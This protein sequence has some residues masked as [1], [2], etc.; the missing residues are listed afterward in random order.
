MIGKQE[1]RNLIAWGRQS[2]I[3]AFLRL[4]KLEVNFFQ[5]AAVRPYDHTSLVPLHFGQTFVGPSNIGNGA[6]SGSAGELTE[7]ER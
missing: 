3:C 1:A 6:S 7:L 2:S 4:S 5:C